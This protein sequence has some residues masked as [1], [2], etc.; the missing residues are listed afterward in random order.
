MKRF[1][2]ATAALALTTGMANAE[3]SLT[4]LHTN[5]FHARFEP[6][7]KYDGPCSAEDNTAG[8]CFGGTARL[9]NAVEAA[10]ARSNNSIL[11]DGGDQFQGTLFYTYYKGKMA[12]EFMNALGYDGMTVGNHEFDDGPE[13]LAGFVDAIDFP[14][15][16]SNADISGEPALADKIAKSTV[17]ERGGERIG[18]IGLTPQDTDELA[19]PG[20]NI[21]FTAPA[22]AVQAEVDKLTADGVNKI[23]V[24]SHSGYGVD[25]DVAANTT[26]VDVIVGGHSNTL[27]GDMEGAEGAYP[28]MVGETAIVQAYAYGKFL[29][30]LNVTFDDDGNVTEAAGQA[31]IVDATVEEDADT[32]ARI[33]ELALPLDEIRN[34]VVAQTDQ[35]IGG[36]R[37][38]CRAQVCE[39]GVLIADAMLARV[40]D[41]GI[42]VAIQNGGGIRASI[43]AGEVTMGDVLTV[44]PF[45]NT[46][47]T[48]RVDG[49]TILA[50]LENGVSQVEEGAGRFPQV[51]GLTFAFDASAEAGSR[52]SDVMI[53]GEPLDPAKVYGVVSNNYVRNGGDGYDMF[54]DADDAYDFGPDLADVTA[55]FLAENGP[56]TPFTDDRINVK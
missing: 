29:G 9:V 54:V 19:S 32:V 35:P 37:D 52:V 3:Y 4:I 47:S 17:I 42:D 7:S 18:M 10:R 34:K 23:I 56:Y 43:D 51:S 38:V 5:D 21:I 13:V 44:L 55:E 2:T 12:A 11:V 16:M 20:P 8:E 27:L 40:A 1:L 50:A 39:M 33:A 46:L 48:F 31:L 25:Q 14:I 24:L 30:E 45:Q 41:Q 28:T 36:D 49:A 15:L 53:G 22:D 6:I 26:G